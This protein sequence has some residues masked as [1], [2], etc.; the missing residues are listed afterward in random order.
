MLFKDLVKL[1]MNHN[2]LEELIDL[3]LEYG[4]DGRE[5]CSKLP[6][7]YIAC[8][9]SFIPTLHHLAEPTASIM[10]Q[11]SKTLSLD[12]ARFTYHSGEMFINSVDLPITLHHINGSISHPSLAIG[13]KLN[14]SILRSLLQESKDD[15]LQPNISVGLGVGKASD[16]LLDAVR[17]LIRTLK[18]PSDRAIL[19]PALEREIHWRLLQSDLG[20]ILK[21]LAM[22]KSPLKKISTAIHWIRDNFNQT[23]KVEQLAKLAGMSTTSLHRH[24]RLATSMSPIQFQK[25]IRLQEAR[26]RLTSTESDVAS[27]A[28]AVG[29][30]S[31]SQF[32]R[33]YKRMYGVPP[34][35]DAYSTK[36]TQ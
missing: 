19:A 25:K 34:I 31:P 33:E 8:Y 9:D 16:E 10:V 28:F 4:N 26:M 13:I 6:F 14:L 11:G 32:S 29:Y 24:F 1:G 35:E 17:R 12:E 23:I 18:T 27:V 36:F 2:M 5:P 3:A 15:M 20:G 7:L 30:E 22:T 21:R